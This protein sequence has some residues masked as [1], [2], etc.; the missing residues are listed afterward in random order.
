MG[1]RFHFLGVLLFLILFS[2][3][4]IP[5]YAEVPPNSEAK[6]IITYFSVVLSCRSNTPLLMDELKL[7]IFLGLLAG[8]LLLLFY[9]SA[10]LT[11]K[12]VLI[13]FLGNEVYLK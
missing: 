3:Q 10:H 5:Q 4:S 7:L 11:S 6:R 9:A 2:L 12:R 13:I 8:H 1:C